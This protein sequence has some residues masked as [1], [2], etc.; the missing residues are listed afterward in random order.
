[1]GQQNN[2]GEAHSNFFTLISK[3]C[4]IETKHLYKPK[5]HVIRG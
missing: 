5:D 2:I 3:A 4:E 1:V